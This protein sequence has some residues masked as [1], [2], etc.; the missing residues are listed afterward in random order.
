MF[1]LW[2]HVALRLFAWNLKEAQ[3][4][5]LHA[6]YIHIPTLYRY[7][8]SECS[9]SITW[10]VLLASLQ[11]IFPSLPNATNLWCWSVEDTQRG[12]AGFGGSPSCMLLI[13]RF[14]LQTSS[15]HDVFHSLHSH[16]STAPKDT[17]EL[18]RASFWTCSLQH[19]K[20]RSSE[21]S[22]WNNQAAWRSGAPASHPQVTKHFLKEQWPQDMSTPLAGRNV[23]MCP[24]QTGHH[25]CPEE[26]R[27]WALWD[28]IFWRSA[29]GLKQ[30]AWYLLTKTA[31]DDHLVGF[32]WF[33][34]SLW[35]L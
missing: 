8:L 11:D 16:E 6:M 33:G 28:E 29:W 23:A 3:L 9:V 31:Q 17:Q 12:R 7:V 24:C 2:C 18:S 1:L 5:G 34:R 10:S 30:T 4:H 26:S 22:F 14:E 21:C 15:M 25:W 35:T 20:L 32:G 13:G 19:E 27:A